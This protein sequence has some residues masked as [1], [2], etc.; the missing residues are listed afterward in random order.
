MGWKRISRQQGCVAGS[1]ALVVAVAGMVD[2]D[3]T[4]SG[5]DAARRTPP[6]QAAPEQASLEPTPSTQTPSRQTPVVPR[7]FAPS[8]EAVARELYEL[9]QA[10]GGS[11]VERFGIELDEQPAA[12]PRQGTP[13][14]MPSDSRRWFPPVQSD[15]ARPAGWDAVASDGDAPTTEAAATTSQ[16]VLLRQSAWKLEKVAQ[17]LE[18]SELFDSADA[19]RDLAHQLRTDARRPRLPR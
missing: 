13:R 7:T 3:E 9:Q 1:L 4:F 10:R 17:Q 15:N 16:T 11:V 19:V 8:A 5:E 2:A 14:G 6:E 12:T 18:M